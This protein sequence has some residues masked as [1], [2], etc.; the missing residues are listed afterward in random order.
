MHVCHSILQSRVAKVMAEHGARVLVL[1]REQQ[2]KDRVRGEWMASWG[3]AEAQELGIYEL[4]RG[5]CGHELPWFDRY[6][7]PAHVMRRDFLSTTPQHLPS[8]ALY[9]N[10]K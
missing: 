1:E 10:L 6:A 5:T 3:V 4:L 8:F 9:H 2:F 7:G